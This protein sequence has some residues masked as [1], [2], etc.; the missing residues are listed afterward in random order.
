MLTTTRRRPDLY[1]REERMEAEK[2]YL[3]AK[4]E[5]SKAARAYARQGQRPRFTLPTCAQRE[6][7][8]A[9]EATKRVPGLS[10]DDALVELRHCFTEE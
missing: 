1:S 10:F 8:I 4:I 6:M 3:L 9:L 7:E 5:E 2:S